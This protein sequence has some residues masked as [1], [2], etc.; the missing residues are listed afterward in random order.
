[1]W[2]LII[3]ADPWFLRGHESQQWALRMLPTLKKSNWNSHLPRVSVHHRTLQKAR[4][5]G[6]YRQGLVSDKPEHRQEVGRRER[7]ERGDEGQP[8]ELPAC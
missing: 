2:V 8:Q 3:L 1:M 5:W 4:G 7:K 6:E